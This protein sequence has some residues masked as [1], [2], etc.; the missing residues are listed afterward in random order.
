MKKLTMLLASIAALVAAGILWR[1]L[2]P[3]P[4]PGA[5]VASERAALDRTVRRTFEESRTGVEVPPVEAPP[6]GSVAE[7]SRRP[8]QPPPMPAESDVGMSGLPEGYSLGEYRG[9]MQRAPRTVGGGPAPS[10]NPE[11]LDSASAAGA[12]LDRAAR[13]GRDFTF[14]VL[15]VSQGTDLSALN[16]RLGPLGARIVGNSGEYARVRVPADA[17]GIEAIAAVAGVVGIGAVPPGLKAEEAFVQDMLSR[18]AAEPVPVFV[19]LMAPDPAGEWRRPLAELGVAAG[20]Y[21]ADLRSYTANM[22]AAALANVLAADFVLSVEPVPEVTVNHDSSVPAMGADGFREFDPATQ[23]FSGI[24]GSGIAVVVLDTG[25]NTSHMDIAHGRASICGANFVADE[26]WDLWVDLGDHGTHVFGTIAGAGRTDPVLAGVAPGLSHLRFGKIL[27]AHGFGSGDD[28]RRGMD[29]LSRPSGCAWQGAMSAAVKP[30]IVNMSLSATSLAFSG[31]GVGERKLDSVVHAHS[32]LYVVAQSNAGVHGFSNYGTAKNSLAVGAVDDAG[33][34]AGFSSHGPTFDGRLAPGV[35]G[36][37]VGLTSARGGASVS[38]HNEFSGTSMAAPSV[39]GVAALLMEARPE[40][41]NRPALTRA[42]LMASAIRPHAHLESRAQLPGD[43]TDGPGAFNN[44]YGLGLVSARMSLFSRDGPEGWLIGSAT[45]RPEGEGYEYIDIEVPE[46]AAQLDIV[47]TWDEQPADTLT[48]SVLN[49]LDLW[50]DHGADCAGDAC[51]EHSSRSEVDN[52]EWLLIE[53]PA[54][55]TYRIKVVPVEIYGESST[56]AVAWKVLIGEPVPQLGVE[57]EDSSAGA[58][59]EYITLDVTVDASDYVASGTTLHLSC[60]SGGRECRELRDSYLPHRGSVS[61]E[62]GLYRSEPYSPESVNRPIP[63]G[64]VAAGAPRRVRLSFLREMVPPESALHVTASSWNARSAGHG[65]ALSPEGVE[66]APDAANT[67]NDGFSASE[68]IAG[69]AGETPL[70]L[71]LTSREPGEPLVGATS[72]TAWYSWDAPAK[73]LYR[74]RL[75][76]AGTG[77]AQVADF[78]LFAGDRLTELDTVAEKQGN[79]ISFAATAGGAYRLRVASGEWD[80]APLVLEWEPADRRPAHDDFAFSQALEGAS[81]SL[82]STNEGATLE[83]SEFLGGAAASVWFEW[84]APEDG[85]WEFRSNGPETH[86]RAYSG[87]RIDDLRLLSAQLDYSPDGHSAVW[88]AKRGESYRIA[89]TA[90]SADASGS[91]FTLSWERFTRDLNGTRHD[92]DM[93][94]NAFLLDGSEGR[95]DV[96]GNRRFT[97]EP[98]EPAASGVFTRWWRWTAP[99]DGRFTWALDLPSQY[100]LTF[101]AGDTLDNLQFAGSLQP[102]TAYVL[103]ATGATR[104][105]I[106]L[107]LTP[108]STAPAFSTPGT[109]AWGPTPANDDRAAA[110]RLV[111]AGGS[112]EISLLYAT[113]APAEPADTVGRDSAWWRWSTRTTGWQRFWV[114]GHPLS[115][116]LSVYPDSASRRSIADS[117]RSFLAN[118]RVE[119]HV[120]AQ[121]GREY[122]IRMASRPGVGKERSATLR[123]EASEAPAFLTYK[124]AVEIDTLAGNPVAQG[125]RSPRRLAVSDDG[126]YLFSAA[127]G[128]LFA[129]LRDTGSGELALAYRVSSESDRDTP[130]FGFIGNSNLWWNSHHERLFVMER[131]DAPFSLGLPETGTSL[132]YRE[133][134]IIDPANSTISCGVIPGAGS[135]DGRHYYTVFESSHLETGRVDSPTQITVVQ[136]VTPNGALGGGGDRLV[137]PNLGS[138]IDV[139][140]TPNGLFLY[141][142]S[143]QGLFAFSRDTST[144]RLALTQEILR[145]NDPEGPFSAMGDFVD[146]TVDASGN[147]LFVAGRNT[148]VP[149]VFD[150]AIAAFDIETDPSGPAHLHTL[151][152]MRFERD[153]DATRAWNHLKPNLHRALTSCNRLVPHAGLAA[154]DVFCEH[155]YLVVYWNPATRTLEVTDF[156]E[157]GS[158]DRFGHTLPYW[159]VWSKQ[160]ASSPEGAHLYLPTG[161]DEGHSDAIHIFE[162]ASGM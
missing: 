72:R 44:L 34:L 79:E 28:I 158:A 105:W 131:C 114:E 119:V 66:I 147:V 90:P 75:R 23:E 27:S 95:L 125:F 2:D 18:S 150:S 151:T 59:S 55:G 11:W 8:V 71:A 160:M 121:A 88:P 70:D 116:L 45:S 143:D 148:N 6:I 48:R 130:D 73:G 149:A 22:P 98:G 43:N 32:Q 20:A 96:A 104:Y 111:G 62:D 78:A 21:D 77:G 49:N 13:S 35:V 107:G 80:L 87:Q 101:F 10:P 76:Q 36:T 102:G 24:T 58:D 118:G 110:V 91:R 39:A 53:D 136:S 137:I 123:W 127:D 63:V 30:L 9:R 161:V 51:G 132:I 155:G 4:E 57:I 65:V 15:R 141:L 12:L 109:F 120:L 1:S 52:V 99:D 94:G 153:I 122:D 14:A 103:E 162:R 74:F 156:A 89:V 83:S 159:N 82:E 56:A 50:A 146:L 31:R 145:N 108:E 138:P 133:V 17:R 93:F 126:H 40:F 157:S 100:R 60:R 19:T 29:Y 115:A 67:A 38:G 42:R 139:A 152:Q 117:E 113:A 140:L 124:G 129:F 16:D 26:D 47:L 81:G 41:R 128:G 68:R 135:S 64:E 154:A 84:T 92:N 142:L 69:A 7:D 5:Q 25:L 86:V 3:L 33:L 112:A 85:L 54:P 97:V 46:H 134:T 144:G 106:A 61:R 37:G